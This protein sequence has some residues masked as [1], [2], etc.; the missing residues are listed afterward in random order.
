MQ[1]GVS[2]YRTSIGKKI[3]MATTAIILFLWITAHMIG[4]LKVFEGPQTF[5]G[6][7]HFLR[8]MGG[9]IF[10]P[11]VLLWIIRVVVLASVLFHIVAYVQLWLQDR[12]ARKKGYKRYRPDVFSFASRTMMW[13]GI[14]IFV[15]VI[16]HLLDLT[17]GTVN[18]G[19]VS[20]DPY[21]SVI[22]SFD[23]WPVAVFYLI[24]LLALGMH[25]YHGVW[26]VFQT[27]GFSN[28]R[29]NRYRRPLAT[30]VAVVI[31]GGFSLVPLAVMAGILK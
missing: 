8:V 16:W 2:L 13:G 12:G 27:L 6:Y 17:F 29:Y 7:A 28:P 19:F 11:T 9:P 1:R 20:G 23:R 14:T 15:F 18:P 22:A 4:N 3:V 25:L 31:A 30:V 24:A 10:P 5:N 21:H 26:S